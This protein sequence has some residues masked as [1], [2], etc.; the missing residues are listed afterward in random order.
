MAPGIV[1]RD[2]VLRALDS[3]REAKASHRVS[4]TDHDRIRRRLAE[5][6]PCFQTY[7]DTGA[8]RDP[9]PGATL[10]IAWPDLRLDPDDRQR[11]ATLAGAVSEIGESEM[12]VE[13]RLV[14][15]ERDASAT[16]T[17]IDHVHP[18]VARFSVYGTARPTLRHAVIIAD[19]IHAALVQLSDGASVFTGCDERGQSRTGP[20]RHAFVYP[21]ALGHD[22]RITHVTVHAPMGFD[23]RAR[24]ALARFRRLFSTR[25]H[26]LHFA[27]IGLG[28]SADF[29]SGWIES[30]PL[31]AVARTWR[32]V[33]PFVATRFAKHTRAGVAKKDARGLVVGSPP[34]DLLRLVETAGL[35]E[36]SIAKCDPMSFDGTSPR[37]WLDFEIRRERGD[38]KV[39]PQPPDGFRLTFPEPVSGPMAFG[40]GAHFGLGALVPAG[41][42]ETQAEFEP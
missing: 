16:S 31:C 6:I 17:V 1:N 12:W 2:D 42:D 14:E 21:E 35:P 41:D 29:R 24:A 37:E 20:H 38:G 18:T 33:T 9:V 27:P 23:A 10:D 4:A 28:H 26:D 7:S 39:T 25:G 19:R 34:H 8:P 3:V 30:S 36:P 32:S 22:D 13:M 40:Y 5:Q 15:W 11:L